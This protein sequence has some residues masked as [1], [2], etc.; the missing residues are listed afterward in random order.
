[1]DYLFS[2]KPNQTLS[3]GIKTL[4]EFQI[5]GLAYSSIV[6][7]GYNYFRDGEVYPN[8]EISVGKYEL[9][10]SGS[11]GDYEIVIQQEKE[12]V[13]ASCNCPFDDGTCKH[14]IASLLH[15]QNNVQSHVLQEADITAAVI[16]KVEKAKSDFE[17]YVDN[18]PIA[19]LRKLVL[20][21][22]P[23]NFRKE[24]T[25]KQDLEKGDTKK[26]EEE[27]KKAL[28]HIKNLFDGELYNI[29]EF[30]ENADKALK[31]LR[32]FWQT[33]SDN[34]ADELADFIQSV[35]E[36]FDEGYLSGNYDDGY[37][38][39]YEDTYEA[40]E[41]SEYIGEFI[42]AIPNDKRKTAL[43]K[44]LKAKENLD[45][46]VCD[47]MESQIIKV[48]PTE[49]LPQFTNT[50]LEI[51]FFKY[52]YRSDND[53]ALYEK[54]EPYLNDD[55]KEKILL[56]NE[57]NSWFNFALAKHYE[58]KADYQKAYDTLADFF[59][60][61]EANTYSYSSEFR[62]S[63]Y[64][65][66]IRLC[67]ENLDGKNTLHWIE[68]YLQT[69]PSIGSFQTAIKHR[70]EKR[71]TFETYLEQN[72][73]TNFVTIL[74]QE[75]RLKTVIELFKKYPQK[76]Q[77]SDDI[78]EFFQRHKLLF[79]K[80]ATPVFKKELD[81]HLQ[82]AKQYHYEKVGEILSELQPILS[83]SAFHSLVSGIKSGYKRRTNLMGVLGRKGF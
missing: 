65:M 6:E 56:E 5:S 52:L 26:V 79:P 83:D 33:H 46:S 50:V 2:L 73:I 1:M 77:N 59:R 51:D 58:T 7:R 18:L 49:D 29:D 82:E 72:H 71:A 27:F 45:Y 21:F 31:K 62:H 28:I 74:E 34:I 69:T 20:E 19:E 48:I 66:I 25:I 68:K 9:E 38:E 15:L 3:E 37:D 22:A 11:Y 64:Q 63:Q 47:S 10:V 75:N 13:N 4:S 80:E 8:V 61:S 12:K 16:A 32:P 55:Q 43:L 70:P 30:V 39:Y 14:I 24:V 76:F 23:E 78:Y 42:G 17:K 60:N 41:V 40:E 57:T 44:L 35:G 53:I 54:I 67:D 81:V 36:A